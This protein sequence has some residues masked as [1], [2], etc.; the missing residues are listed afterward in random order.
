MKQPDT[1]ARDERHAIDCM[2]SALPPLR[3][4]AVAMRAAWGDTPE[5]RIAD[6]LRLAMAQLL[7][8]IAVPGSS[9]MAAADAALADLSDKEEPPHA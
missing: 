9:D 8:S 3:R 4:V 1:E 2:V 6:A 7:T 5:V